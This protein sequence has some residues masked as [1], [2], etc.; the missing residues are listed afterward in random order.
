MGNE[1]CH[2]IGNLFYQHGL[3]CS[4]DLKVLDILQ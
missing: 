2:V 1:S 3:S 4:Q